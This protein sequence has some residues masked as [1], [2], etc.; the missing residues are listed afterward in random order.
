MQPTNAEIIG[1]IVL[2]I[3]AIVFFVKATMQSE[4]SSEI[5]ITWGQRRDWENRAK[6][7]ERRTR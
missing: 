1:W 4:S 2:L 7:Y 3:I 6:D 5:E